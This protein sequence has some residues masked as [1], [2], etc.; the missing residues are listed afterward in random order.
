MTFCFKWLIITEQRSAQKSRKTL[1]W[2][3]IAKGMGLFF[4]VLIKNIED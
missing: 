1:T 2:V 3:K 4:L